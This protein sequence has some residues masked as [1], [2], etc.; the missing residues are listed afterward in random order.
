METMHQVNEI[1]NLRIVFIETL[2]RQFIAITG[3]GIYA[4]LNPVTINEL[5]NQ[6]MA[7][8]VPINAYARQCVRNVVA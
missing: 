7:S 2:S 5:F 8:N 4:Y 6:Y 3:C 1:N